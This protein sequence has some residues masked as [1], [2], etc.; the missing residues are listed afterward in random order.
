MCTFPHSFHQNP[1]D[2]RYFSLSYSIGI[3]QSTTTKSHT[4]VSQMNLHFCLHKVYS[5]VC[6]YRCL[7]DSIELQ[8]PTIAWTNLYYRFVPFL[9]HGLHLLSCDAV[10]S[11]LHQP[12]MMDE[13][14]PKLLD[15]LDIVGFANTLK[16]LLYILKIRNGR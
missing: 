16:E 1:I 4:T 5:T 6:F 7:F 3:V 14:R 10:S 9:Q 11:L 2:H 13:V 15:F 12:Q 8:L